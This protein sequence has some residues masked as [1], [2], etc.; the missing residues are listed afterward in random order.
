MYNPA[1]A[2]VS[3]TIGTYVYVVGIQ[4]GDISFS[5]AVG[6]FQGFTSLIIVLALNWFSKRVA[7]L[8]LF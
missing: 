5:V 1:V 3:E 4:Q 2:E 8:D 7:K 6:I